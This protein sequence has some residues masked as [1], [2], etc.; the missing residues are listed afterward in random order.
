MQTILHIRN[1][2]I[3]LQIVSGYTDRITRSTEILLQT[4]S[5][6][7]NITYQKSEPLDQEE[8]GEVGA[9]LAAVVDM[10]LT[11][12]NQQAKL[13]VQTCQNC[14]VHQHQRVQ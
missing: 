13:V 5:D 11:F 3:L 9:V 12:R 6:R 8:V 2:V 7:R 1:I 10:A 14:G 4:G